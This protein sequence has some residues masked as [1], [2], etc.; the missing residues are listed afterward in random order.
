MAAH[1]IILAKQFNAEVK[2][3]IDI[4]IETMGERPNLK[5]MLVKLNVATATKPYI[6]Y[7]LWCT[8]VIPYMK[9]IEDKNEAAWGWEKTRKNEMFNS[10]GVCEFWETFDNTTKDRIWDVLGRINKLC[11]SIYNNRKKYG[12]MDA[13]SVVMENFLQ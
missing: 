13:V 3:L 11:I 6:V 4:C 12:V 10:F 7:D 1:N 9:H 2:K 5:T 8:H